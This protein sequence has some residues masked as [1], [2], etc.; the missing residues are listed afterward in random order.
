[1]GTVKQTKKKRT[2]TGA[3]QKKAKELYHH[4]IF[5]RSLTFRKQLSRRKKATVE[6][7]K[8][9]DLEKD[10]HILKQ[11]MI[12]M[13]QYEKSAESKLCNNPFWNQLLKERV[14]KN[15]LK[16]WKQEVRYHFDVQFWK[17]SNLFVDDEN[18]VVSEN[19][20]YDYC[21]SSHC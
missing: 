19:S 7:D 15:D 9:T 10:I 4:L 8:S 14:K 20:D 18:I 21:P 11:K 1:M 16:T 12:V 17:E 3:V 2:K 6:T 13:K 5:H